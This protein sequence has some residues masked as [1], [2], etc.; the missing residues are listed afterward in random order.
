MVGIGGGKFRLG[1][2]WNQFKRKK[3]GKKKGKE[4]KKEI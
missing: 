3:R 4:E 1:Q 2:S